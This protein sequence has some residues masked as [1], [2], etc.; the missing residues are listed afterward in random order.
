MPE[1]IC[2]NCQGSCSKGNKYCKS[3][4][5]VEKRKTMLDENN[6]Y[7][8]SK[9]LKS[10]P[11]DYAAIFKDPVVLPPDDLETMVR[12]EQHQKAPPFKGSNF[13]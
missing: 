13:K 4:N 3:C 7:R 5:T 9:G 2:T 10:L 1:T 8:A 11:A 12:Y 6:A